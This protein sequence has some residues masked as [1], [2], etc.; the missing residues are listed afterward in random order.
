MHVLISIF[1]VY[2]CQTI[3]QMNTM[4]NVCYGHKLQF[5]TAHTFDAGNLHTSAN[6]YIKAK[7]RVA[8]I[9]GTH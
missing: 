5:Q 4:E 8:Q 7:R 1:K 2:V 6:S 3:T 9:N